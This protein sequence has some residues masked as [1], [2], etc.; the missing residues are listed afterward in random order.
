M[1][2]RPLHLPKHRWS[3]RSDYNRFLFLIFLVSHDVYVSFP[4]RL[5]SPFQRLTEL[6]SDTGP[7]RVQTT[8]RA[9]G[10]AFSFGFVNSYG[11]IGGAL[12]PQIFR[13]QYAPHYTVSFAV[14]MALVGAAI[15]MNFLTWWVTR[16]TERDTVR[17]FPSKD[18]KSLS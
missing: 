11:Q 17:F 12:G 14:A 6:T 18:S 16:R 1:L 10:S 7:W 4:S 9:T 5:P 13:S 3:I 2:C 15:L 8:E